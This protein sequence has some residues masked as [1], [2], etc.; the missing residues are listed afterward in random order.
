MVFSTSIHHTLRSALM[1]MHPLTMCA[2]LQI[3][4]LAH[5]MS[6]AVIYFFVPSRAEVEEEM[7]G[8]NIM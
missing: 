8:Y 7:V 3:C 1:M 2:M 6:S 4:L 5:T